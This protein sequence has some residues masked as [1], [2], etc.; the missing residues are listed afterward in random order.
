M[1]D[2]PKVV[3]DADGEPIGPTDKIV[4]GVSYFLG[5]IGGIQPFV[6]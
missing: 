1:Q 6:P 3:L 5:T 2:R 4:T